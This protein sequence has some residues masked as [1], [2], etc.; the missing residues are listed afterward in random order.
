M[1]RIPTPRLRLDVRDLQIVLAV[2]A[3]G[4]TAWELAAMG[5][6]MLLVAVAENQRAVVDPL[7]AAGAAQRLG[8]DAAKDGAT[9]AGAIGAFA[10]AGA[11]AH[12]GMA[13]ACVELVDGRGATRICHALAEMTSARTGQGDRK[14]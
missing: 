14:E 12:R 4:S 6:P 11:A 1:T 5:V 7:V 13:R 9:L 2:A 10:S 3:A 8:L